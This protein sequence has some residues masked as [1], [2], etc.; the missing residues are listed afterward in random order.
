MA[1][2]TNEPEEENGISY[3]IIVQR[4]IDGSFDDEIMVDGYGVLQEAW[5]DIEKMII[6]KGWKWDG[7]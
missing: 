6:D 1:I 2:D 5:D 3:I 4:V 7:T